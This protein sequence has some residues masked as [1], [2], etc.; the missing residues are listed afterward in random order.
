MLKKNYPLVKNSEK[1]C[2]TWNMFVSGGLG[3]TKC[4]AATSLK[5]WMLF[6]EHRQMRN[7]FF[8]RIQSSV[9]VS[10]RAF[11]VYCYEEEMVFVY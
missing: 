2:K 5:L 10:T 7:I 6:C 4:L 1:Y 9:S 8:K 3:V 11:I